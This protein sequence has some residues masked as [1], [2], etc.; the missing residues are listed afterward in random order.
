MLTLQ[1]E[2]RDTKQKL[3][4]LR[5][6]G[7]MP[8][9]FYGK[10][11]ESTPITLLMSDFEKVWKEAG[12]STVVTLKGVD[13]EFETIIH[14]VTV[15]PVTGIPVHADFYVFEKGQKIEVAISLEFTG[16]S[17]AVKDLGGVLVK[18]L[19]E[20]EV[21]AIPSKLPSELIVDISLL[22]TFETQIHA[23]DLALPEGVTLITDAEEVVALVEKPR[24][25][26]PEEAAPV[27]LSAIEV[28]KRGKKE[29]E[30]GEAPATEE[31]K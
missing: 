18:V 2:K 20:V 29:D 13:G 26:E 17:P 1:I 7:S 10:K 16:V 19:H 22:S 11:T 6:A 24:E 28:E 31:K 30:E 9:V 14:D 23:K 25:E 8:A 27:D 3:D 5:S 15:H 4:L 12:E 21:E